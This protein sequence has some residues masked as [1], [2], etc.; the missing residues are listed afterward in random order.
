L[1]LLQHVR[2]SQIMPVPAGRELF[3]EGDAA[4]VMYVLVD[5][6][7]DILVG[8]VQVELATPGTL[9]GEMALV[10]GSRRSATV[11]CRTPCRLVTVDK[12]QFDQ[13]TAELPAFGRQVMSLMAERLRRMNER[14]GQGLTIQPARRSNGEF[15]FSVYTRDAQGTRILVERFPT[16]ELAVQKFPQAAL[17]NRRDAAVNGIP[18]T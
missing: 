7:A 4:D 17:M 13:L 15:C 11:I 18:S 14:V 3:R 1:N 12:T 16:H 6:M 10:D 5:G 9:F 8:G 2:N